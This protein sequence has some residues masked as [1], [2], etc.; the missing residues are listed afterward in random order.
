MKIR[1]FAE[2]SYQEHSIWN[3]VE[4]RPDAGETVAVVYVDRETTIAAFF[5]IQSE[6]GDWVLFA[7]Y[8]FRPNRSLAKR[9]ERLN[10]FYGNASVIREAYF[11]CHGE[12]FGG[13]TRHLDLSTQRPKAP[14]PEFIDEPA[15]LY[16]RVEDLPF[17]S[18][19]RRAN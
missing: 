9:H 6:S 12:D 7:D 5:E 15:P 10:T 3:E 14:D 2:A 1:T 11:G 8:Y 19:L 16:K 13:T 18:A 17:S 4:G